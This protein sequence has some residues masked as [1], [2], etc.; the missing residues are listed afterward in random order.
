MGTTYR[1]LASHQFKPHRSL[2]QALTHTERRVPRI[3]MNSHIVTI[4]NSFYSQTN[5]LYDDDNDDDIIFNTNNANSSTL[6]KYE[7][8]FQESILHKLVSFFD[9]IFLF[10][11]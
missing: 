1:S 8:Y 2:I 3:E 10:Y 7:L 4:N 6:K 9:I 11:H 5:N